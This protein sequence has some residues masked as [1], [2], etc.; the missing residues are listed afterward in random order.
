MCVPSLPTRADTQVRPYAEGVQCL[1][2]LRDSG[3]VAHPPILLRR[4]NV[5]LSVPLHALAVVTAVTQLIAA[6]EE[7]VCLFPVS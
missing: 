1:E 6:H 7:T 2:Y 5:F 4:K 3:F